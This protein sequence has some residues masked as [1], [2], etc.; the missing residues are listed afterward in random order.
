MYRIFSTNNNDILIVLKQPVAGF[1]WVLL[2][3]GV[4]GKPHY[5]NA[6]KLNLYSDIEPLLKVLFPSLVNDKQIPVGEIEKLTLVKDYSRCVPANLG[7]IPLKTASNKASF[8]EY[9]EANFTLDFSLSDIAVTFT[10]RKVAPYAIKDHDPWAVIPPEDHAIFKTALSP[11]L[12]NNIESGDFWQIELA[13]YLTAANPATPY[14][15]ILLAGPKGA[16][17]TSLAEFIAAKYDLPYANIVCT[18]DI[19]T[20]QF[21][22]YITVNTSSEGHWKAVMSE[23]LRCAQAGGVCCLDEVNNCSPNV[24]VGLNSFISGSCRKIVWQGISYPVHPKTIFVACMNIGYQG[25]GILNEAFEDRFRGFIL[26]TIPAKELAEY[27]SKLFKLDLTPARKF[28]EFYVKVSDY[29]ESAYADEDRYSAQPP[30]LSLRSIPTLLSECFASMSLSKPLA[31]LLRYSLKGIVNVDSTVQTLLSKYTSDIL[32]LESE[33]F[34]ST[35]TVKE[36]AALNSELQSLRSI[37]P[38]TVSATSVA[39]DSYDSYMDE[40]VAE[41]LGMGGK[42]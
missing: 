17:K 8:S 9:M 19:T 26:E 11:E 21:A 29:I 7:T 4:N 24:Q 1:E 25:N 30:S 27:Y 18:S 3:T 39:S 14:K 2:G 33:L 41:T 10:R 13:P 38:L 20:E 35:E 5:I 31:S 28:I 12:F 36:E 42:G 34:K 37:D 32:A 16:G 6:S 40:V 22:G 23:F 15:N